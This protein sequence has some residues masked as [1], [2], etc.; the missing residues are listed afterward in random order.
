MKLLNI[1][2][3]LRKYP[4]VTSAFFSA[5]DGSEYTINNQLVRWVKDGELIRLKKGLY[6]LNNEDRGVGLSQMLIANI[7][8]YPSYV[9]LEYALSY[10]GMIP[11]GV[12]Q[13]T[14]V[15]PKKTK[16]FTNKFGGFIYKNVAKELFFGYE[17]TKD[18]NDADIL[19]ATPEKALLDLFYLRT[20][21]NMKI[22]LS[23]F[24]E[25]LRLQNLEIIDPKK[26]KKMAKKFKMSKIG[27]IVDG[28][29]KCRDELS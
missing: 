26:M 11:E 10:Y 16:D 19:I 27:K 23:Y 29:L 7:L 2:K 15:T 21:A 3:N 13:T 22:E 6:T 18:E 4:Y 5:Q 8:Y 1:K 17:R 25:N 14:S 12:F 28:L 9:S 20:P 24:E